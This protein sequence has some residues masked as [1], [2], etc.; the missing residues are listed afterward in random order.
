MKLTA[1]Q[2]AKTLYES[3]QET[4]IKDQSKILDN[5][6]EALVANNDIAMFDEISLEFDKLDKSKK[7]IKIAEV[8]SAKQLEK[9][10]EKEIIEHLNKM[11]GGNVE[12]RKKIDDKILGGVIIK[13]DD[14]LIDASVKK[15]LE[16]LKSDLAE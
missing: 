6:A 14:T 2:Y 12:L 7:G 11:V 8:T 4:Q 13:V 1:L 5:F 15:A 9:H 10:T 3:L 16:Q